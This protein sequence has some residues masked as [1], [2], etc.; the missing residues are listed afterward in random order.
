[1][2]HQAQNNISVLGLRPTLG[3]HARR[4]TCTHI[5]HTH[6]HTHIREMEGLQVLLIITP[7]YS[8]VFHPT[9]SIISAAPNQ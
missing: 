7:T 2:T 3:M 9:L 8:D 6:T 4:H 1:M 5:G